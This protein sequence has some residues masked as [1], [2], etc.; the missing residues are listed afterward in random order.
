M[1]YTSSDIRRQTPDRVCRS[2]VRNGIHFRIA[3]LRTDTS[4]RDRRECIARV[5]TVDPRR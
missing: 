2:C 3:R 1:F 4:V 5:L